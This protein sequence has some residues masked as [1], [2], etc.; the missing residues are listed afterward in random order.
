V[1]APDGT[2]VYVTGIRAEPD[3]SGE[4][5][6]VKFAPADGAV[7]WQQIWGTPAAGGSIFLAATAETVP[8]Y[9]FDPAPTKTSRLRGAVAIPAGALTSVT[10]VLGNPVGVVEA[11]LA[12]DL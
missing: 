5:F 1:A 6:V 2:A 10:G 12:P 8:P 3:D 7:V 9:I 11:P 4:L